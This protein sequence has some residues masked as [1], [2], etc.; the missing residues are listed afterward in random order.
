[1]VNLLTHSIVYTCT[2]V[3][4][5]PGH[6]ATQVNCPGIPLGM[7]RYSNMTLNVKYPSADRKCP[8]C[9]V[10]DQFIDQAKKKVI[11]AKAHDII[12]TSKLNDGLKRIW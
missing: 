7:V 9:E 2:R 1:M 4:L 5:G 12:M 11:T 8:N 3:T 6:R 10:D